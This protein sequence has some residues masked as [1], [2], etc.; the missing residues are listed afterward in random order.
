M[1]KPMRIVSWGRMDCAI[2]DFIGM[3]PIMGFS[4]SS[5]NSAELDKHWDLLPHSTISQ[6]VRTIIR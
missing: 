6:I 4:S 3:N 5:S 1:K 2:R